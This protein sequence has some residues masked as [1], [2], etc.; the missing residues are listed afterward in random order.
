[1]RMHQRLWSR[2]LSS[3]FAV[4]TTLALIYTLGSIDAHSGEPDGATEALREKFFEQNVRPLLGAE[5]LF[6][7]WREKAKGGPEARFDRDDPQ[8]GRIRACDR[9]RQARRKPARSRNQL[10]RP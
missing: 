7:P 2:L 9:A 6:L 10:R 3:A 8:G 4:L 5:L 1:M